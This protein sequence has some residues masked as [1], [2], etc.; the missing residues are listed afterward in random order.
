MAVRCYD[1]KT[2]RLVIKGEKVTPFDPSRGVS[3]K[4]IYLSERSLFEALG[5]CISTAMTN[6]ISILDVDQVMLDSDWSAFNQYANEL[7]QRFPNG[8]TIAQVREWL[9]NDDWVDQL[10]TDLGGEA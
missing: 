1:P 5:D 4:I 7:M 10:Y 6:G 2:V 8:A 9:L 3:K